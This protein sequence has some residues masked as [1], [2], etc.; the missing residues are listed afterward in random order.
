MSMHGAYAGETMTVGSSF[1]VF[2][3]GLGNKEGPEDHGHHGAG[4]DD[5]DHDG[6]KN[7]GLLHVEVNTV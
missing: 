1:K 4:G 7:F 5:A 6:M 3:E 2:E